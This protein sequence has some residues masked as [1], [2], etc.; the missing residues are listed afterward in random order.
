MAI[1]RKGLEQLKQSSGS[2]IAELEGY[3]LDELEYIYETQQDLYSAEEL[4]GMPEL[5]SSRRAAYEAEKGRIEELLEDFLPNELPCHKCGGNNAFANTRCKFC[6]V[7]LD[8]S[9]C[10]ARARLELLDG[11]KDGAYADVGLSDEAV[12]RYIEEEDILLVETKQDSSD[13]QASGG[14]YTFHYVI[15]VLIPLVGFIMGALFLTKDDDE[16]RSAGKTCIIAG[17][18]SAVVCCVIWGVMW[19]TKMDALSGL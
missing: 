6:N 14:G 4:R 2:L 9:K 13:C 17:I 3:T 8:K 1:N 18:V 19:A 11:L 15:S 5:I 10:Y 16:D 7:E 12:S